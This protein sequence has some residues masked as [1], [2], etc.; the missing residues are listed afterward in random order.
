VRF[1][2]SEEKEIAEKNA[3]CCGYPKLAGFMK[4]LALGHQPPSVLDQD[5]LLEVSALSGEMGKVGGLLKKRLGE[6]R[7]AGAS[8]VEVASLREELD[9][10][11][12][13]RR[14]IAR[15]VVDLDNQ[16]RG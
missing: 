3:R 12:N 10:I 6:M 4:T 14:K 2:S 13:V 7:E 15:Y 1:S 9:A 16:L 8:P 11:S 5:I